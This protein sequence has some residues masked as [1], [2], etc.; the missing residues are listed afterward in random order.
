MAKTSAAT[1]TP[2]RPPTDSAGISPA[3]TGG[4][5]VTAPLGA[6]APHPHN[7]TNLGDLTELTASIKAQGLF[8]PLN[9]ITVGG[10][11]PRP[12]TATATPSGPDP[13][14]RT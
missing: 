3:A 13:G 2:L 5:L 14:S 9:V 1:V 10:P 4:Q 12:R 8:E 6:L 7:R 11:S